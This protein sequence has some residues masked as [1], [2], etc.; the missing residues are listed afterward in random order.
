MTSISIWIAAPL[1]LVFIVLWTRF[2]FRDE[3]EEE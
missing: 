2:L 1:I 3:E